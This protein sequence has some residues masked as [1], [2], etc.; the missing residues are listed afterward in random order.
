MKK[1]RLR[2]TVITAAAVIFVIVGW[3]FLAPTQIGG[4]TRYVIT[5][6]NSMAPHFH[7]G[8]LALVRP[9]AQYRVGQIVAY[10]S[11]LLHVVVL[12]RIIARDG[13]GYVMKGDHNSFVDPTHPGR[14]DLIGA[15]W[16]HVPQAGRVLNWLHT[17][18]T[19]ASLAGGFGLLLLLTAG[20]K[21]RRRKR[22]KRTPTHPKRIQ[23]VNTEEHDTTRPLNIRALLAISGTALLTFMVLSVVAFTRPTRRPSAVYVPYTQQVA[24]GY[25]ASAPA[26][27]VYPSGAVNTGDPIF[28]ALVHKVRVAIAYRF[29]A[30][31]PHK[32]TGSEQ[33]LLKLN[34]PAGWTRTMPLTSRQR[35][36]TDRTRTEVTLDLPHL[37]SLLR[38]VQTLTGMQPDSSYSLALAVQVHI[39]GALGGQP[40]DNDFSPALSFALSPLQ[41]VPGG[42]SSNGGLSQSGLIPS[43]HGTVATPA[44]APNALS[45][46]GASISISELRWIGLAGLALAGASTLLLIVLLNTTRPFEEAARIQAR[47]SHLIVPIVAT[48]DALAWAPFDVPS[49]KALV[50]IAENSERLILHHRDADG[51]TYLVNDDSTVYRY[52]IKAARVVWE[53]WSAAGTRGTNGSAPA[54]D[55]A[56]A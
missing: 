7:T 41:L 33:V 42:G 43:M 37:Q 44:T 1:D 26:G 29:K 25:H 18:F 45:A 38:R 16:L 47:Y 52:R 5:S 4:S 15:L 20:E 21:R 49:I 34:G 50:R 48:A 6:G 31:A 54:P 13:N 10:R 19:A 30:G 11:S 12:H 8:D 27:A 53:D 2:S 22:R 51:E 24:F 36:T 32:L 46:A 28:L 14:A 56:A 9:A 40:V 17:P 23:S 39:S 55:A 3:L 35:F